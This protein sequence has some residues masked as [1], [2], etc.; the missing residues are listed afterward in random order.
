M[1][2]HDAGITSAPEVAYG[3]STRLEELDK[4]DMI[5]EDVAVTTSDA[6]VAFDLKAGAAQSV[7]LALIEQTNVIPTTGA[8]KVTTQWEYWTYCAFCE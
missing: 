1:S 4:N 3:H 2:H 8:R 6:N 7:G 5:K